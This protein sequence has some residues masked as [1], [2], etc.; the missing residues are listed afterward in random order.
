MNTSSDISQ[1]NGDDS[2]LSLQPELPFLTA[3]LPGIGGAIKTI[4]SDFV[5]EEIPLYEF[6]GT[7]THVLFRIQKKGVTTA[8]TISRLAQALGVRRYDIGYAGRKDANA[9]TRQWFSVEH[10]DAD[11]VKNLNLNKIKILEVTRHTN[12]LKVGHLKGNCF[13][14]RLRNLPQPAEDAAALAQQTMDVL[15]RRGVPNYFGPQ[16]FG[17]RYDS[18]LLGE[19]LVKNDLQRF[20]DVL[21]GH[22]ESEPQEEFIQARTLYHQ[23][24]F[25]AALDAWHPAFRDHRDGLKALMQ[26]GGKLNKALRAMDGRLLSLFVSAWQSDLFNAVLAKRI[27]QIDTVLEGDMAYKH[28]N[29]ACF[30]VENPQAEQPRC[31]AFEISPTGPLLGARMMELTGPAGKIENPILHAVALTPEDYARIRRFGGSGGRRPLRFLPQDVHLATS[32]DD[33]GE[34]LQLRF[35]LPSG[36]YA[37]VLLRELTKQN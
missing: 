30:R 12:K 32:A 6:S 34:F 26:S 1:L 23:G 19:A 8:E 4:P 20:F 33:H 11:K 24:N 25:Q 17:Y 5:V 27:G 2:G 22:P 16:R 21:L 37:T 10:I 31:T 13:T 36:C 3:D 18:H 35:E 15:C 9:I 14:I 29:G 28:N 7:G